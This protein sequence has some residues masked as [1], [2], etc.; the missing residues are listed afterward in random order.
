[1]PQDERAMQDNDKDSALTGE[2]DP[3][4]PGPEEPALEESEK[5]RTLQ[6]EL[7]KAKDHMLRVLAE[8]E[9]TRKR[10]I[11]ERDEAGKY[12]VAGFAREMLDVAD[13]LR[14]GLEAVPADLAADPRAQ[15]LVQGIEATER[16]LLKSFER[17]GIRKLEPLGEIFNPN[18]HE[19]MFETPAGGKPAGT[20]IQVIEAGY[21]LGERLL[22]PA[23]VGVAR[24]DGVQAS[25]MSG[26]HVDTQA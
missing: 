6:D 17:N 13:N 2:S 26:G 10:A 19:V 12:A 23:R 24:E 20:V 3:L 11:R 25:P 7:D 4:T 8:A 9:N 5:I 22:R 1:M 14:R 18:F 21:M 15:A 16:A